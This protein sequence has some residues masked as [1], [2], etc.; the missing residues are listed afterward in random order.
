MTIPDD[1]LL[2]RSDLLRDLVGEAEGAAAKYHQDMKGYRQAEHDRLDL[3]VEL[4]RTTLAGPEI[5]WAAEI[6]VLQDQIEELQL[7]LD[8][9]RRNP[10]VTTYWSGIEDGTRGTAG[11]WEE[12]LTHP[13]PKPGVM[14]EPLESLYRQTEAL[15]QTLATT[16]SHLALVSGQRDGYAWL[17]SG[18]MDTIEAFWQPHDD[19]S[20]AACELLLKRLGDSND[21]ARVALKSQGIEP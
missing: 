17:M 18:V 5:P 4:G 1:W 6:Q 12:A 13:M 21:A 2:I 14:P 10:E 20:R 15:R 7:E 19:A 3:L 8:C 9:A 16:Q 11:R